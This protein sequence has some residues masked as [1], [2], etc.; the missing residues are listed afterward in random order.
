MT[1]VAKLERTLSEKRAR[2]EEL[3]NRKVTADVAVTD[4]R[5]A[6]SKAALDPD[7]AALDR[8][9]QELRSAE[10]RSRSLVAACALTEASIFATE[11]ELAT[12]RRMAEAT[13]AANRLNEMASNFE[14]DLP[15][16]VA[17]LQLL[18]AHTANCKNYWQI[19]PLVAAAETAA[20]TVEESCAVVAKL[21]RDEAKQIVLSAQNNVAP[22]ADVVVKLANRG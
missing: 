21:M 9:E 20:L 15:Q 3:K 17:G 11:T 16:I 19:G 14:R 10:D 8:L 13:V 5:M 18:R 22:S 4:K 2:F 7:N 12:A 6:C 1:Q